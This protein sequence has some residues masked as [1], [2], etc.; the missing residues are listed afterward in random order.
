MRNWMNCVGLQ[1]LQN[2]PSPRFEEQE[3]AR[4]GIST[5]KVRFNNV[6][7]YYIEISKVQAARVPEDYERR[8]TLANAERYTTPQLKEW[9]QKIL[10]AE[11]RI[12]QIESELFQQVRAKV[13]EGDPET[14]IDSESIGDP[15]CPFFSG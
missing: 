13:C 14:A 2:R 15:G 4:S 3:R 9:E 7:G 11:E 8:Q 12:L 1:R 10:G 5:L 6:F